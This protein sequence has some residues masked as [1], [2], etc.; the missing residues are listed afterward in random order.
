MAQH[1][2]EGKY[3]A[4]VEYAEKVLQESSGDSNSALLI[5]LGYAQYGKSS[6]YRDERNKFNYFHM[7][8]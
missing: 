1:F 7:M 8:F 3:S 6:S 4:F 2:L 5:N